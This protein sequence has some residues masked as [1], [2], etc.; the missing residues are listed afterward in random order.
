MELQRAS[1]FHKLLCCYRTDR[2]RP[3]CNN[4]SIY[5]PSFLKPLVW[6]VW[7]LDRIVWIAVKNQ[8]LSY[9]TGNHC[10]VVEPTRNEPLATSQPIHTF[11]RNYTI[12]LTSLN[13]RSNN[14]TAANSQRLSYDT[15]NHYAVVEATENEIFLVWFLNNYFGAFWQPCVWVIY[16]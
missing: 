2:K 5:T 13:S 1:G 4:I 7:T 10:T 8:R 9:D 6:Q 12:C 3:A 16:L 11:L 14:W 15:G